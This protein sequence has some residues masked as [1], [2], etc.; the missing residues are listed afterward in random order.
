EHPDPEVFATF[1]PH[2]RTV[3]RFHDTITERPDNAHPTPET[4]RAILDFGD[5]S[6]DM[7]VSHLLV[8]CHMG[9]SRSTAAAA[10]LM[11]Q[12]NRGREAEAFAHLW[13]IRPRSWPNSRM[14]ALADAMLERGGALV[15]AMTAHHARV[16]RAYPDFAALLR[17][18]E[19]AHEVPS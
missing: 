16:A 4:V 3:W 17:Q 12:H 2:R 6:R 9:I 8:H 10:I 5:A 14:V 1:G 19:R 7:D 15:A 18:G 13:D 11:A